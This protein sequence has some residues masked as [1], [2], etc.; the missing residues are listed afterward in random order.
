M[1]NKKTVQ[2]P[3]P[4]PRLARS[5]APE[6]DFELLYDGRLW[7]PEGWTSTLWAES[8]QL[9]NPTNMDVDARGRIWI[10]EAVN[11]RDFNNKPGRFPHFAK[12]DRVV[13]LEDTN[14]DGR[15]DST[16]VFVQDENLVAPD[17]RRRG[18]TDVQPS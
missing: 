10:T 9:Y 13:I 7:L 6:L 14:G 8:P 3:G 1:S 12:G 17:D 16:K 4:D 18:A 2:L 5:E 11:Y 15:A